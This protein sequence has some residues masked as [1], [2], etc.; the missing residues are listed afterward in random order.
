MTM[1]GMDCEA[2]PTARSQLPQR[3]AQPCAGVQRHPAIGTL[4]CHVL[5]VGGRHYLTWGT[6][7]GG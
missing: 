3:S 5:A 4:P 1:I 7:I 2:R 6:M